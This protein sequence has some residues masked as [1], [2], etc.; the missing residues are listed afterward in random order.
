MEK[1]LKEIFQQNGTAILAD[2]DRLMQLLTE[3]GCDQ[4]QVMTL[5][6]LLK[7]CPTAVNLLQQEQ[8]TEAESNVLVSAAVNQTGLSVVTTRRILNAVMSAAG[9]KSPWRPRLLLYERVAEKEFTALIPDEVKHLD[10]LEEQLWSPSVSS[11][12]IHDL[13]LLSEK[14]SVRAS[15]ML[16]EYFRKQDIRNGT[17]DGMKYFQRAAKLGY[18]PAK[19][20]LADYMI[21]SNRKNMATAAACFE[22]PSSITGHHGRAWKTLAERLLSYREENKKRTGS[23]ILLQGLFLA[24]TILLFVLGFVNIGVFGIIALVVQVLSLG[25]LLYASI[26]GP[27]FTCKVTGYAMLFSWL[28]LAFAML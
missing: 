7:S 27:Y 1:E 20:A 6:L 19:G 17:L 2:P 24:M 3:R 4:T 21:R 28:A 18:G 5:G 14:G 16:G 9:I 22:D 25:Y 23:M 12:T 10:T 26:F 15:Y 11:E 8:L 13:D